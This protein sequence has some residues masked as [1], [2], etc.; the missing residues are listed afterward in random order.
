MAKG[1]TITLR[2]TLRDFSCGILALLVWS[3]FACLVIIL[4]LPVY[5]QLA[6]MRLRGK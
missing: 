1:N 3:L 6:F 5:L 2:E 4:S